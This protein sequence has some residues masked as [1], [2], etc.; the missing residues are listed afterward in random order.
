M[1]LTREVEEESDFAAILGVP[2]VE[3][4]ISLNRMLLP[5]HLTSLDDLRTAASRLRADILLVYTFD[6]VFFDEDRARPLTA[7][8]LGLSPSRRITATTT[9]SALILDTRTGFIYGALESTASERKASSS[10]GTRESAD[11]A[12]MA[13]ERD[14]FAGVV[15]GF[16][17]LWPRIVERHGPAAA[18]R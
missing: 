1:V 15:S 6:T 10:W 4:V 7:I 12:R 5:E 14:A 8:T 18:M 11:K 17:D 3:N 13:T 2:G 16:V 9:A